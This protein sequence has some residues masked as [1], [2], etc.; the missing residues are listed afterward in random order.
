MPIAI[1]LRTDIENCL[2]RDAIIGSIASG[3]GNKVLLCSGFF[4]ENFQGSAYQ[5]TAEPGLIAG[6]RNHNVQIETFGIHNYSWLPSYK[7]FCGHLRAGG[8]NVT[9]WIQKGFQ[10]HAKVFILK[11]DDVPVFGIVGSSNIT[12][13]AFGVRNDPPE[14]TDSPNPPKR[15]NYETDVFLWE[16]SNNTVNKVVSNILFPQDRATEN[17]L[18]IRARYFADD[19]NGLS[20]TERLSQLENEVR[21]AGPHQELEL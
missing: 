1:H 11:K 8:V 5:A 15:F 6:L 14:L 3:L 7:M 21:S 10:W 4:Q 9:A 13:N 12:A 18:S 16:E 2:Y 20:I 19:N 17:D